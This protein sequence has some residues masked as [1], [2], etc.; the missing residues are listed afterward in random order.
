VALPV[1]G[2]EAFVREHS[3]SLLRT[4]YLLTGDA[5][6][7][8]DLLQDAL[9]RLY[10]NWHRVDAAAAPVAYVRRS[11]L[12]EYLNSRRRRTLTLVDFDIRDHPGTLTDVDDGVV[13]RDETT[14]LLHRLTD[15]Q[16]ATVVLRYFHSLSD[17]EIA[18]MLGCREATVRSLLRRS[19]LAM[20]AAA[21]VTTQDPTSRGTSDDR[22]E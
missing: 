4:S 6:G 2:F 17:T 14:R 21:G 7:A 18:T 16:R 3:T 13:N 22:L 10:P 5:A 8:E 19:L 20:R 1:S 15:R 11:L 12:N 9:T